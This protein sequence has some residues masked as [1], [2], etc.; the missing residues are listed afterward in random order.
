MTTKIALVAAKQAGSGMSLHPQ[1]A[2]ALGIAGET[3]MLLRYGAASAEIRITISPLLRGHE[4]ALS[5]GLIASLRIP[6]SSRYEIV[7]TGNELRL[8]PYVGFLV[9]QTMKDLKENLNKIS[10]YLASYEQVGGTIIAFALSGVNTRRR[11]IRGYVFNPRAKRWV[12]GTYGYPSSLFIKS[13]MIPV[14]YRQH[15]QSVMGMTIFNNFNYDKWKMYQLLQ[16]AGLG[17]YLP[18]S[19][20]YQQ[21]DELLRFLQRD[22]QAYLKPIRGSQGKAILKITRSASGYLVRS[23]VEGSNRKRFL[24]TDQQFLAFARKR[25]RPRAYMMQRA[26][27][28]YSVHNRILDFRII[29]VKNRLG[30]WQDMGLITRY[31][32]PGSVVSNIKAGGSAE[33]GERTLRKTL[34]LTEHQAARMRQKLSLLAHKVARSLDAAGIHCGNMGV[35]IGIDTA[36]RVWIIEIQHNNPDHTLV[37][38]ANENRMFRAILQNNLLYLKWLAGFGPNQK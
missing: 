14:R 22:A 16:T 1:V 19:Q 7:V 2:E 34:G 11:T 26:I 24:A 36:R 12:I 27:R 15:F 38:D 20:L 30:E 10:A 9:S 23:R 21:P 17:R 28:L 18:P 6:L 31:G 32:R 8:G 35:D 37:L 33:T 13:G 5:H 29:M 4:V 3:T 25:L